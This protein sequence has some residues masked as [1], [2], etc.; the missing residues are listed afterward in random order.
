MSVTGIIF[1]AH[2][3]SKKVTS[4]FDWDF[5]AHRSPVT[6]ISGELNYGTVSDRAGTRCCERSLPERLFSLVLRFLSFD[7]VTR[8]RKGSNSQALNTCSVLR[9][10]PRF[11]A[12]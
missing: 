9:S 4:E 1:V 3:W 5:L 2:E 10:K 6:L 8:I 7:P 11:L 12:S